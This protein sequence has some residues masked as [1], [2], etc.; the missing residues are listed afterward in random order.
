MPVTIDWVIYYHDIV[1]IKEGNH[2]F[3]CSYND[4]FKCI[5]SDIDFLAFGYKVCKL[6]L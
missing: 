5:L 6:L 4:Y 1:V 3:S 2:D